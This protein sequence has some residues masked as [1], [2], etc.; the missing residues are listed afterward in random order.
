VN[1]DDMDKTAPRNAMACPHCHSR[2]RTITSRQLSTLVREIYFDCLNVDCS[3]RCVAQLGIVRTLVPSL[4]PNAQVS[5]PIVARRPSDIL[6]PSVVQPTTG[7]APAL[8][9]SGSA[10]SS[11]A[12]MVLN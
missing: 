10:G 6:M 8:P 7:D 4:V 9:P 11:Y 12:P 5:L 2:M 3:H 1:E